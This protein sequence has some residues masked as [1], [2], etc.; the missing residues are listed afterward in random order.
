MEYTFIVPVIR[1]VTSLFIHSTM[2]ITSI[3]GVYAIS[4]LSLN[5][6]KITKARAVSIFVQ[7]PGGNKPRS[8][9]PAKT[10]SFG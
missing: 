1:Q 8:F 7:H 10:F 9:N 4:E 3:D 5:P 6:F 2:L